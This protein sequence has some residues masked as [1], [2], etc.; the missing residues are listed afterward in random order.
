MIILWFAL[1]LSSSCCH[2]ISCVKMSKLKCTPIERQTKEVICNVFEYCAEE[3]AN[4]AIT[5]EK[6]GS[7]CE[8]DPTKVYE[9]VTRMTGVSERTIRNIVKEK[10]GGEFRS[11]KKSVSRTGVLNKVDDFDVCAIKRLIYNMYEEDERVTLT[12]IWQKV[13]SELSLAV[14]RTALR[15]LLLLNGF[16]YRKVNNRKL[17]MERPCV[18]AARA[19]YLR[20][21]RRVRSTEPHRTVVYL[22][23]TWYNQYDIE[24]QAWLDDRE[25]SG[26]KH[27]IGKGKRLI[28][29]HAGSKA[30]FID[31]ALLTTWTDGKSADYHDS[32]NAQH[33]EEWFARLL[34]NIPDSSVIVMDNASYHSRQ[35]NKAPTS[36]N[37]KGE[38]QAWLEE[39]SISYEEDML[40]VELL[41]LVRPHAPQK[42]YHVDEMAK[43]KGHDV[44]RLAPYSCDLNPIELIWAQ[45]K[46]YVRRRNK[47]GGLE[48][49]RSLIGEA[50]AS[51]SPSAWAN[52]C[53]HVVRLEQEYWDREH[54][55]EEVE[56]VVIPL[57]SS[58]EDDEDEED[59][60]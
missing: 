27:V 43:L 46:A 15:K 31:G 32:M 28:I 2:L 40:K 10:E 30:G 11:P 21:I 26:K 53:E 56:R 60:D 14:G 34:D 45:V 51:V 58:D 33:F 50:V 57:A 35:R 8:T 59:S 17:L 20:E 7:Y 55:A 42:S 1:V 37:K 19:R 12:S 44:L 52:C 16:R 22:D 48:V 6:C 36:S 38:L 9:R 25:V 13:K 4:I 18:R 23:E 5:G 3:K 41:E 39:N 54:V 24:Q 47:T 29:V 49:I